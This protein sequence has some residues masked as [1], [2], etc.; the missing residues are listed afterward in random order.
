VAN[1]GIVIERSRHA[2]QFLIIG[3]AEARDTRISFRARGLH[4]HLLSLPPGWR[5]TT[6]D[7][8]K[9][10]PE[11]RD[12][13]RTALNELISLGYVTKRKHQDLRGHW[14][15]TVT[16]HDKPQTEAGSEAPITTEDGFPGAGSPGVGESGAKKL[17]T[18]TEDVEDQEMAQEL[19][20]RRAQASGSRAKRTTDE[21][22]AEVREAVA[23]IH[24]QQEADDLTD[25]EVLGLYFKYG[26]PKKPARDLV[27]YITKVLSDAPYLDTFMAN[28]EAVCVPCWHY[29]SDCKCGAESAA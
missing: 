28:V 27:A 10:N 14:H 4:H 2:Q 15:T 13:V 7:L 16:V 8:A 6:T 21:V 11:G 18:V 25:G 19:A 5:V 17:K 3:N 24:G 1:D 23:R 29:E 12:A 20:S 26:N 22:I 9:D